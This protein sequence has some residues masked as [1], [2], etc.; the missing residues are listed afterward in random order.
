MGK[1]Y[2]D[3]GMYFMS[4]K[5]KMTLFMVCPVLVFGLIAI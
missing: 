1:V 3:E 5:Q 4:L 2:A